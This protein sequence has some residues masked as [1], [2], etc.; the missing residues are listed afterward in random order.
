M[1]IIYPK[2]E[3][4]KSRYHERY[5]LAAERVRGIK[6]ET[7]GGGCVVPEQMRDYFA[8]VSSYL[9]QMMDTYE[10]V[11]TGSFYELSLEELQQ[12]AGVGQGILDRLRQVG[13]L[14]DLP[15]SSQV[16]FF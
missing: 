10:A 15:E 11:D 12:A 7:N 4:E 3:E 1:N 9:V 8:K 5:E 6:W 14:G 16:S 13:A 2:A